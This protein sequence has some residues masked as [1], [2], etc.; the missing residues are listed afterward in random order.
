LD[1]LLNNM[2]IEEYFKTPFWF[3]EKLDFLKS[4]TKATDKYIKEAK[5]IRKKDI[6]MTN[7]FGI[8]LSFKT[9]DCGY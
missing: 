3:E 7:D 9:I 6:K 5:E 1:I 8:F 2:F 4:L